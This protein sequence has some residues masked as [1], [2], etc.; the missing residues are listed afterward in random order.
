ME[1]DGGESEIESWQSETRRTM[2]HGEIG[3]EA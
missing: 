1:D 2:K 3:G